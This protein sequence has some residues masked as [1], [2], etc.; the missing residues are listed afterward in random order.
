MHEISG[1]CR[2]GEINI[3][4][5][6]DRLCHNALYT[7]IKL[8]IIIVLPPT[9]KPT[10]VCTYTHMKQAPGI[11]QLES[12]LDHGFPRIISWSNYRQ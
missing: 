3:G 6:V 12:N 2:I 11:R 1:V 10:R 8:K 5:I 9:V 7:K 4:E